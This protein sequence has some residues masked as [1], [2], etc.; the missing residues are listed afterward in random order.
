MIILNEQ[1]GYKNTGILLD[2]EEYSAILGGKKYNKS[3]QKGDNKSYCF[4]I[5]HFEN[6]SNPYRFETSYFVGV[7]WIVENKLPIY[8]QPKLNNE[9]TEINYLKMLFEALQQPENFNHLDQLCEINFDAPLISIKQEQDLLSPLL[10]VQYLHLLKKIVQKGLKK[11][12]YP[13]VKNLNAKV[14]GKILVNATIKGNHSKSKMLF[15]Y[16]KYDEFGLNSIENKVLKK[17]LLFSQ[18]AIQN[19]NGVDSKTLNGLFNYIQPAFILIEDEIQIEEL[20]TIKPN[21]LYKEYDQALKLAKLILKRYG[22]TI[23]NTTTN[24]IQTPPFWID[25]SKLFELYVY[26]KLKE[27]FPERGEV[28]YHKKFNYLEPDYILNSQKENYK[29]VVDAKYK[30][31]YRNGNV[32]TE[33]IRQ[34][35]GY[36]RLKSVYK[37]LNIDNR[38]EVIDC[39]IIYSEQSLER[40]DLKEISLKSNEENNYV[41]FYKIGI[42]LPVL[43]EI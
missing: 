4:N 15:N 35:S 30:P 38:N 7:D 10:V 36:A 19:L 34:V 13:V 26:A 12:Y 18:K 20:K 24:K 33:D 42:K 22:Y 16:C 3:I 29:M 27:R 43:K 32:N 9:N 11:S 37:H 25:M 23:S 14:K 40:N 1:F 2:I 21:P 5:S 39:L 6:D 17:A 31:Q 41:N 8:V 28:I